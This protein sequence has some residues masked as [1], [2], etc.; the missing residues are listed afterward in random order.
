MPNKVN[1]P[2]DA[3]S[4]PVQV[5]TP[6]MATALFGAL[7]ATAVRLA[8]PTSTEIVQI[9]STQD[10][11]V[12]FGDSTVTAAADTNANML[13][14]AGSQA[15]RFPTGSTH[16]SFVRDTTDGRVGVVGLI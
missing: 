2:E 13:L 7:T 11:W 12:K 5:L 8:L 16:V 6:D 9:V 1:L 15:Y 10:M 4:N 14:T 3:N